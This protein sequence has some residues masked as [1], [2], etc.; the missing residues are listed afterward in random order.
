MQTVIQLN[1]AESRWELT[2]AAPG[3]KPPT[4][5]YDVLSGL[6][7]A[8][9][10]I[11][12]VARSGAADAPRCVIVQSSSERC[13]CAGANINVLDTLCEATI[14]KW[15]ATGHAVFNRLE[16]LPIP[17]IAQVRG[18]ALGGGLELA[19]A[20][21]VIVCDRTA[22][23][24]LTEANIGFVPGWGGSFRLPRRV[25]NARAKQLFFSAERVEADAAVARGLVDAVV[26]AAEMDSWLADYA[27]ALVAKS[28]VGIRGF[29]AIL[30]QADRAA[31]EANLAAETAQSLVCISDPDTKRRIEEFLQKRKS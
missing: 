20:C 8:L 24:G 16:D 23:L 29:K 25:G 9:A 14:E 2:L 27:D 4:L 15:I 12:R 22:K 21:D 6:D 30:N 13:F 3:N 31:R 5:D 11:E 19:L 1:K 7:E 18:Y 28:Q 26:D 17:V 10:E